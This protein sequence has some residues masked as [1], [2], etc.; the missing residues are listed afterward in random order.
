MKT[1]KVTA[2]LAILLGPLCA[3]GFSQQQK[4]FDW[5]PAN[6][7]TV[8]LDPA[9][10]HSGRNYGSSPD[11][12]KIHVDIKSQLPVTVFLTDADAWN[13]ALQHPE[14]VPNLPQ[15]CLQQR[16]VEL[17]YVCALPP[18]PTT[19]VIR[20][21]RNSPDG[22]VFAGLG[23]VLDG[24]SKVDSA[25]AT[26]VVTLLTG[27]GSATH[28]FY[29][30][31][32]VHIQYYRW[33]CAENCVQPEF[34]WIEQVKEKYQL[35]SFLKVYGGFAP[36]HDQTLVS[37]RINAPTPMI[38]AMLPSQVADQL[39]AKPDT[40]ETALENNSCQQRGVQK[41]QFQ[42]TFNLAD[43]PQS[44]IVVPATPDVPHK[45]AEVEMQV[46]KCVANC[47]LITPSQKPDAAA[48]M[49]NNE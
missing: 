4:V 30:P 32:D 11:G 46:V 44:L 5:Q 1:F 45:K 47:Q 25:V 13:Q 34:Q 35:T 16:V 43:G 3:T 27:E 15:I 12:G 20:D 40:L 41:L 42:C 14:Y 49:Q 7:E 2:L 21:E 29:S 26:G 31:N 23:A 6:D 38:V 33:I 24:N 39:Y 19:L 36:D 8:R 28:K 17:T 10:Y 9:N 18:R 22:A 48:G 37:I